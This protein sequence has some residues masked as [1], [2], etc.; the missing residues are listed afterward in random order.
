MKPATSADAPARSAGRSACLPGR[1]GSA[2]CASAWLW[3]FS[4]SWRPSVCGLCARLRA[5]AARRDAI[6]H[7]VEPCTVRG[8]FTAHGGA[9]PAELAVELAFVQ[10]EIGGGG[11]DRRAIDHQPEMRRRHMLS[12]RLK[13]MC[14]RQAEAHFL[15]VQTRVDAGRHF[16][17]EGV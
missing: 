11:A 16:L 1:D 15:A 9:E 10:H 13:A 4:S 14:H 2:A 5:G 7:A 6:L 12:T 8:A 17:A 3:P